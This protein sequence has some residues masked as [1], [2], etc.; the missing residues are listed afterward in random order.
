MQVYGR[1]FEDFY[2]YLVLLRIKRDFVYQRFGIRPGATCLVH[3]YRPQPRLAYSRHRSYRQEE[4]LR[5]IR[6]DLGGRIRFRAV[7]QLSCTLEKKRFFCLLPTVVRIILRKGEHD[8]TLSRNCNWGPDHW[9]R[10][11]TRISGRRSRQTSARR[12]L[13]DTLRWEKSRC[14]PHDRRCELAV[15]RRHCPGQQRQWFPRHQGLLYGLRTE[16]R[17]LGRRRCQQRHLYSLRKSAANHRYECVRGEYIR[18]ASRPLLR[19][20]RHCRC[21]NASRHSYSRRQGKYLRAYGQRL[22]C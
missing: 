16:G 11:P 1:V 9:T 10:S 18:Q 17:V 4:H 19:N 6:L 14:L 2:F 20:R 13:D 5:P 22:T 21:S 8:E 15:G 12:R 7:A 3:H